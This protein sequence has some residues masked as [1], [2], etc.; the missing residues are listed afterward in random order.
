MAKQR[1]HKS[2]SWN[3][4]SQETN[5][6]F[7]PRP[8][9]VEAHQDVHRSP[10]Q[11]QPNLLE[12]LTRN[13]QAVQTIESQT[14]VQS[15]P[16]QAKSDITG[17]S[18]DASV[19]QP[20]NTT[21]MPDALKAGVEHLSGYSLD[22]VR[23][24]YNSSKP[25]Q[26]QALAYAQGT[27]I[28]VA[29]GQEEHLPH[30]AW[31]VVQQM[32]GRVKPTMQMMKD[33][34]LVNDD[35]GLEHKAD[36][37]GAKALVPTA[38]PAERSVVQLRLAPASGHPVVQRE[39]FIG[40]KKKHHLHIDIHQDHYTFGTDDGARIEIGNNGNYRLDGLIEARNYLKDNGFTANGGQECIDWLEAACQSHNKWDPE[41]GYVPS[42]MK[43]ADRISPHVEHVLA[44]GKEFGLEQADFAKALTEAKDEVLKR[45]AKQFNDSKY[46][47]EGTTREEIT[48]KVETFG[49]QRMLAG[50]SG[51][52][53]GEMLGKEERHEHFKRTAIQRLNEMLRDEFP[54]TG[55][56]EKNYHTDAAAIA[57][58]KKAL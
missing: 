36:V 18:P 30:E 23:V 44:Q 39:Q 28:H 4:P 20:S 8:F 13:A 52:T 21:G 38:Q 54:L 31:H 1:I 51:F 25:A 15:T 34:V 32:Q 33:G 48:E 3:L 12:I 2:S 43:A 6:Q 46:Y 56:A 17:D 19:G 5:S 40:D 26:L 35:A 14:P 53:E 9:A 41:R 10:T 58:H 24:H 7:A 37:M 27:D 22:G 49:L 55:S 29:P 50:W 47:P 42:Y 57:A 11:Q 16:I 45:S